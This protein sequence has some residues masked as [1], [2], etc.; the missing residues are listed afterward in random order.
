MIAK[1]GDAVTDEEGNIICRVKN[2]LRLHQMV[3]AHDFHE[4]TE[5]NTPWVPGHVFDRRCVRPNAIGGLQ[6]CIN[7]EWRP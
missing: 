7:G 4:F 2:D 5:G 3:S 1:A 6:I